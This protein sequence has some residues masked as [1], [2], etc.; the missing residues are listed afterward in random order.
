MNDTRA[1]CLLMTPREHQPMIPTDSPLRL[2]PQST[3]PRQRL[4]LDAIRIAAQCV[5]ISYRRLVENLENG[6]R[7]PESAHVDGIAAM[8]DAWSVVDSVHRLRELA[9]ALPKWRSR[10]PSKQ[11]F[12]R[13]TAAADDLRNS[14]QHL[15]GE[16]GSSC[17][18][19]RGSTDS[20]TGN[21]VEGTS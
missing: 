12:L 2:L 5:D 6:R 11:V 8:L 13:A 18:R 9:Q 16:G 20:S 7:D 15:G 19:I 21:F 14:I 1:N 10:A 17:L 3:D 4:I